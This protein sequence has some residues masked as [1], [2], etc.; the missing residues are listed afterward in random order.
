MKKDQTLPNEI[1]ETNL[2]KILDSHQLKMKMTYQH[3]NKISE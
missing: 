2:D 3:L 1:S